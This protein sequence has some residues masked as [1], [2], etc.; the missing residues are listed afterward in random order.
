MILGIENR[1]E[2]VEEGRGV[3]SS[4]FIRES[5]LYFARGFMCCEED[6]PLRLYGLDED[7]AGYW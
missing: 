2:L 4:E 7:V 3:F 1:I 5:G 6:E